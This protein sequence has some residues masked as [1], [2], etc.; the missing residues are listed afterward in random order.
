MNKR[1]TIDEIRQYVETKTYAQL[2]STEY[3]GYSQKLLFK[4]GCGNNFEKTWTKF[5]SKKQQT[6]GECK[7][8]YIDRVIEGDFLFMEGR[9]FYISGSYF[10]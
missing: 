10:C 3:H 1:W 4:C 7:Y 8:H 6:C 9:P 2:L 5:K